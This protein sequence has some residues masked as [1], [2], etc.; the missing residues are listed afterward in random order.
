MSAADWARAYVGG[1]GVPGRAFADAVL[2]P[3]EAVYRAWMGLRRRAY[4]AGVPS[5]RSA[6]L[7]VLSVGNLVVGGAGKTPV[8]AFLAERLAR[9]GARPAI[10]HGGYAPDEPLLHRAWN[11]DIPVVVGRDRRD[12][13]RRAAAA[14]ADVAVLDDGFQ[15]LRLDRAADL[16]LVPVE[17]WRARPRLL[18]RGPWREPPEALRHAD[19]IALTHRGADPGRVAGVR[20]AVAGLAAAPVAEFVLEA[21]GW[22]RLAVLERAGAP[23]WPVRA[24]SAPPEAALAVCAI[25]DPTGFRRSA[26]RAG[27]TI[28]TLITYGDHHAYDASDLDRI[29]GSAAGRPILTT[30]KDAVKL[31]SLAGRAAV[32]VLTE[33]VRVAA[34]AAEIDRTLG[35]LTA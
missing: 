16:V 9:G 13:V 18:P 3:A 19:L 12:A 35:R 7:P 17:T 2:T 26:E 33:R 5:P 25:A 21:V 22:R 1:E 32:W 15:H 23:A 29:L 31:G 6:A 30:E 4:A 28:A 20:D 8:A 27:A 14:G 11:P 24:E 34:G 10:V